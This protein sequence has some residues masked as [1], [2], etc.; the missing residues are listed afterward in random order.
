[1]WTAKTEIGLF[2]QEILLHAVVIELP[3]ETFSRIL[4]PEKS[5][6]AG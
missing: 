4:P 2:F 5:R 6:Q 3:G 1:M